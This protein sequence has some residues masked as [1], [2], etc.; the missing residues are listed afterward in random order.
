M[1]DYNKTLPI[2]SSASFEDLILR[3]ADGRV[4]AGRD[5]RELP[6]AAL[7]AMHEPR[8]LLTAMRHKCIDSSGYSLSEVA[9][10]SAVNCPLENIRSAL[11]EKRACAFCSDPPDG[12]E[13]QCSVAGVTKGDE[14]IWLHR[15]CQK[16]FMDALPPWPH[17]PT[18]TP[19]KRERRFRERQAALKHNGPEA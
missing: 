2:R 13:Q 11:Q 14:L 8:A 16:P 3:D 1:A 17:P 19:L 12:T 5:P 10:C 7:A 9:H 15:R 6:R 18:A 4:R